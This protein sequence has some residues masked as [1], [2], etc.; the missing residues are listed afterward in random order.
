MAGRSRKALF[1]NPFY[2]VLLV[3]SVV[4]TV[5]V[6]AYLVSPY[7]AERPNAGVGSRALVAWLDRRGP[8]ALGVELLVM[9]VAG[10]LAMVTDRWFRPR[11]L[12]AG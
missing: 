10:V 1:P 9:L 5:T 6:L 12:D 4:F 3:A 2:V 7:A 11:H 8:L